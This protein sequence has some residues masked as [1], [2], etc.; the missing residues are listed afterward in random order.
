MRTRVRTPN[1]IIAIWNSDRPLLAFGPVGFD[2]S[3]VLV[4]ADPL[5]GLRWMMGDLALGAVSTATKI[6]YVDS[7]DLLE[8]IFSEVVPPD[9]HWCAT[10]LDDM[11]EIDYYLISLALSLFLVRTLCLYSWRCLV[12]ATAFVKGIDLG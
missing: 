1:A 4:G 10:T 5:A 3:D 7:F 11:L 6:S 12:K 9:Y 2:W 8:P